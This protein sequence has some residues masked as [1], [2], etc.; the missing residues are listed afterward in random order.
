MPAVVA[1]LCHFVEL[2]VKEVALCGEDGASPTSLVQ[3]TMST[4]SIET[5]EFAPSYEPLQLLRACW[6]AL[7]SSGDVMIAQ[8]WRIE[9]G[10]ERPQYL[11][12]RT[13][14]DT[15][16]NHN[17]LLFTSSHTQLF[18]LGARPWIS[19]FVF[20]N[21]FLSTLQCIARSR[22]RGIATTRL[23]QET[24][25][26]PVDLHHHLDCLKSFS[27]VTGKK[28]QVLVDGGAVAS[29]LW[30][31][32]SLATASIPTSS[33]TYGGVRVECPSVSEEDLD[34]CLDILQKAGGTL[35]V[36]DFI[37]AINRNPHLKGK[38]SSGK[39]GSGHATLEQALLQNR[40]VR[41]VSV[42][43]RASPHQTKISALQIYD[44]DDA[45]LAP[46]AYAFQLL[47]NVPLADQVKSFIHDCGSYGCTATD[48]QE[49]L[50]IPK[51][52]VERILLQLDGNEISTTKQVVGH[53]V[54]IVYIS[55]ITFANEPSVFKVTLNNSKEAEL[56]ELI[57]ACVVRPMPVASRDVPWKHLD[58]NDVQLNRLDSM[59]S[60]LQL[61][62]VVSS[63]AL[64]SHVLEQ[65]RLS[66]VPFTMAQQT[67]MRVLDILLPFI[68]TTHVLKTVVMHDGVSVR[69]LMPTDMHD[70]DPAVAEAY[71]T[72]CRNKRKN[73]SIS[74]GLDKHL[75]KDPVYSRPQKVKQEASTSE[76]PVS[77]RRKLK[78]AT[79]KDRPENTDAGDAPDI[80][81]EVQPTH[82]RDVN[83]SDSNSSMDDSA[84]SHQRSYR[85]LLLVPSIYMKAYMLHSFMM[86]RH[87]QSVSAET[88]LSML[89]YRILIQ[90]IGIPALQNNA[91]FA[92]FQELRTLPAPAMDCSALSRDAVL[93]FHKKNKI[94]FV[95]V[96][97]LLFKLSVLKYQQD[98]L[99]LRDSSVALSQQV[100]VSQSIVI[101]NVDPETFD[102]FAYFG[103]AYYEPS[104]CVFSLHNS[105]ELRQLWMFFKHL[106]YDFDAHSPADRG[107]DLSLSDAHALP[108]SVRCGG[109]FGYDVREGSVKKC[110]SQWMLS[111]FSDPPTVA[112]LT[113][114]LIKST[115]L[116]DTLETLIFPLR[117][118]TRI[119]PQILAAEFY[120]GGLEI[121]LEFKKVISSHRSQLPLLLEGHCD[122]DD[123]SDDERF[124]YWNF[125]SESKLLAYVLLHYSDKIRPGRIPSGQELEK[126]CNRV[127]WTL[128]SRSVRV[129]SSACR[130]R[131][132]QLVPCSQ[133]ASALQAFRHKYPDASSRQ[134]VT[135]QM[136]E[137]LANDIRFK[138][139]SVID[140]F[141]WLDSGQGRTRDAMLIARE[142][143]KVSFPW[144]AP[145]NDCVD[146][147]LVVKRTFCAEH[148]DHSVA[149]AAKCIDS[150]L[151]PDQVLAGFS[152]LTSFGAMQVKPLARQ[153]LRWSDILK[154]ITE[155]FSVEKSQRN[156][157]G[158][159]QKTEQ[160]QNGVEKLPSMIPN[161]NSAL[162][163][164]ALAV[165]HV[166]GQ[167]SFEHE[168]H[169]QSQPAVHSK[170]VSMSDYLHNQGIFRP[171][172]P[173]DILSEAADE[174]ID[175]LMPE[176]DD[177]SRFNYT[178]NGA[179]VKISK[180]DRHSIADL[181][182][183][184]ICWKTDFSPETVERASSFVRE[185]AASGADVR[186]VCDA[187]GI[188]AD[189]AT[190]FRR[191]LLSGLLASFSAC[192][193]F[194]PHVTLPSADQTLLSVG[195]HDLG[196]LTTR[197]LV[198]GGAPN[199]QLEQSIK[200]WCVKSSNGEPSVKSEVLN[201]LLRSILKKPGIG[202]HEL[203][204]LIPIIPLSDIR[205][206]SLL[207]APSSPYC[208]IFV[209][210]R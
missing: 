101:R 115:D 177:T 62:P 128:A 36:D 46:S 181:E 210:R 133:F 176:F 44:P 83:G 158:L 160:F 165:L 37:H 156:R 4:F 192:L 86:S 89:P 87:L 1:S 146:T 144:H 13:S 40:F 82:S 98:S 58:L 78:K 20:S 137:E 11:F 27:L 191:H 114:V 59:Y 81:A 47:P 206:V 169:I 30:H 38:C 173:R 135:T 39:R 61:H 148:Y 45:Q 75:G 41:R 185:Q 188:D 193:N 24:N 187:V 50:Q 141:C 56:F 154:V 121:F 112:K 15:A 178:L 130:S 23:A 95:R 170:K 26:Q 74:Y 202:D 163:A 105:T 116:Q 54:H 10:D 129:P 100:D 92:L 93:N 195:N 102:K 172:K 31:L 2:L 183:E 171:I 159:H 25:M 182:F 6:E 189:D 103:C 19:S 204:R 52:T 147:A 175:S 88:L 71:K 110:P 94:G 149:A 33:E 14:L 162:D 35:S 161:V 174:S 199:E 186:L 118:L 138:A 139:V 113:N 107:A 207:L 60:Y 136:V 200:L 143:H 57:P 17:L 167:L 3:N 69:L 79:I 209:T 97:N 64:S 196:F 106:A 16:I 32:T 166:R 124:Q 123:I 134:T 104:L 142:P 152:C 8:S 109:V 28:C 96:W 164:V 85:R 7:L 208:M 68:A 53:H 197:S 66:G 198:F 12:Q 48:I 145:F 65:E 49:R 122:D 140:S 201:M 108:D 194:H 34:I 9:G 67:F 21:K 77:K 55:K 63:Y 51:K 90:V 155:K 120:F 190:A 157:L 127:N 125:D 117:W 91:F 43:M 84:Y 73:Q 151:S 131:F 168:W 205:D 72:D 99:V 132:S 119:V 42:R 111:R 179:D 150:L 18:V 5:L 184:P 80:S 180:V 70:D 203:A 29:S 22:Q 126:L 76:N 153:V